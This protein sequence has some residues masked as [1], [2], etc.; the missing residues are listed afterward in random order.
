MA[1]YF[2]F[3]DGPAKGYSMGGCFHRAP[4]YL[5]VVRELDGRWDALDQLDDLPNLGDTIFIYR[6][7]PGRYGHISMRPRNLSG[8]IIRYQHTDEIDPEGMEDTD[9][10]RA[11]VEALPPRVTE[12]AA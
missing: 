5:R 8:W 7:L 12:G 2:E 6:R 4:E 3:T 11:A 9:A 10:W 1:Y